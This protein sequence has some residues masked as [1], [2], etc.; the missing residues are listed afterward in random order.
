[1][2]APGQD[3][4][5]LVDVGRLEVWVGDRLPGAGEPLEVERISSGASNEMF[6]LRRGGGRWILR[7]PPRHGVAPGAHDV[8]RE[9]R[10]LRALDGTPV[11][12]PRPLLVCDDPSVIGAPFYVMERIDGFTPREPLPPPFD[13]D[14][15]ARH[16][17]GI[18]L[19]DGLAA[20]ALVDWRAAGLEGFGRPQGFLERQVGR[21][22]SQLERYRTRELPGLDRVAHWLEERRPPMGEPAI[23]HGDYQFV[24]VMFAHGAP[25]RLAAIVDW[26]QSTIG[27]PLLDLGWLLAGWSEEGE[28]LRFGSKY[29]PD[30]RGFPTRDELADRYASRTG[31]DLGRL[32]YYVVLSLFK[33]ACVLEGS[34][35]RF[36]TGRSDN[37]LHER[38]GPLVLELVEQARRTAGL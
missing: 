31:R 34:Y 4:A 19:V 29:L 8:L 6:E 25:A 5:G 12:H 14:L 27:D 32:D 15:G 36:V 35:Y 20:L 10:V 11:P 1:V 21:W 9:V 13:A 23:I 3:L 33:L 26:E 16:A 37:P 22:L 18:A 24:N 38:M 2:S 30:R 28:E 7:R 17:M